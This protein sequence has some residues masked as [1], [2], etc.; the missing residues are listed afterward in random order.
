MAIDP[1]LTRDVQAA[2][3]E[4]AT[5][6]DGTLGPYVKLKNTVGEVAGKHIWWVRDITLSNSMWGNR[7][8]VLDHPRAGVHALGGGIGQGLAM[9]VGA[10]IANTTHT[11]GRKTLSLCGDGGFMLNVGE[12]ACAAQERA[13]VTF[14]VMNDQRYGVIKN[15]QDDIYGSRHAYVELHTPDFAQLCASLK[16]PHFKVSDPAQTAETL[17]QALGIQGPAVLEIDMDAWG[18]FAAKFAGPPKKKD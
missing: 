5:L 6:V 10:A 4:S 2:R 8:P 15:I 7:A 11:L 1:Q 9:G 3:A 14:I 12:L 16:V 17:R 18:P 13:D